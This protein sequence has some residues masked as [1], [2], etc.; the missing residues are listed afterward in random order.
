MHPPVQ[1]LPLL[2]SLQFTAMAQKLVRVGGIFDT[3]VMCIA[4][5]SLMWAT[6]E[7]LLAIAVDALHLDHL[8]TSFGTL[9]SI[10]LTSVRYGLP[11][12]VL[13]DLVHREAFVP[14]HE[15]TYHLTGPKLV[16]IDGRQSLHILCEQQS[17][18]DTTRLLASP[19][20]IMSG[21]SDQAFAQAYSQL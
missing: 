3:C 6:F 10:A 13:C 2:S 17:M 19:A 7:L 12:L 18:L 11:H 14:S 1:R 16:L 5:I 21:Q 20:F 9:G 4:I 8:R 15:L